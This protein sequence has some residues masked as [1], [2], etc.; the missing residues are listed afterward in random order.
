MM[1]KQSPLWGGKK[2]PE[3]GEGFETLTHLKSHD[4]Y[5][6]GKWERKVSQKEPLLYCARQCKFLEGKRRRRPPRRKKLFPISG[7]RG[8]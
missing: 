3:G 4:P 1:P 2:S 5:W 6:E 8:Y 7:K